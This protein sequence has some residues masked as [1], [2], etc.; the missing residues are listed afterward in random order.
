MIRIYVLFLSIFMGFA[1]CNNREVVQITPSLIHMGECE[2]GEIVEVEFLVKNITSKTLESVNI[3]AS[4]KCGIY[5]NLNA[6]ILSGKSQKINFPVTC[7][8]VEGIFEK[9]FD[10][11]TVDMQDLKPL[12]VRG[13]VKR[14]FEIHPAKLEINKV[15]NP[16]NLQYIFYIETLHGGKIEDVL[17]YTLELITPK[18]KD[19]IKPNIQIQIVDGGKKALGLVSIYSPYLSPNGIQ[20]MLLLPLK[21][22]STIKQAK[23]HFSIHP[24]KTKI[25]NQILYITDPPIPFFIETPTHIALSEVFLDDQSISHISRKEE[26]YHDSIRSIL[27]VSIRTRSMESQ[28]IRMAKFCFTDGSTIQTPIIMRR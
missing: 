19:E 12:F 20:G 5:K 18:T 24:Q 17:P 8:E 4:C 28:S 26:V 16:V 14:T 6:T 3:I 21:I 13:K 10:L 27:R 7:P 11:G 25:C 15:T 22:N 23:I 9:T 1:S 2:P